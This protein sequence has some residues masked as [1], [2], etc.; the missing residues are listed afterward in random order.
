MSA[1]CKK[2]IR[3]AAFGGAHFDQDMI[4][5]PTIMLFATERRVAR[6]VARVLENSRWSHSGLVPLCEGFR[7]RWPVLVVLVEGGH[8]DVL[9]TS[10]RHL[11]FLY[12]THAMVLV[13]QVVSVNPRIR[14]G[15]VVLGQA[16]RKYFCP[17]ALPGNVDAPDELVF[18]GEEAEESLTAPELQAARELGG[19]FLGCAS[20]LVSRKAL[21]GDLVPV[22]IGSS[23]R[24]LSGW[25]AKEFVRGRFDVDVVDRGGYGFL[26]GCRDVGSTGAILGVVGEHPQGGDDFLTLHAAVDRVAEVAINAVEVLIDEAR[27]LREVCDG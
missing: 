17:T 19:V 4:V 23:L 26:E 21:S 2:K 13:E 6:R 1:G 12:R 22:R 7:R 10:V 27:R 8:N 24:P 20:A 14:P 15:S 11:S 25:R 16:A 9:Y 3:L 18:R 5:P